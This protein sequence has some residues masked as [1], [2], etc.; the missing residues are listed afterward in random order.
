MIKMFKMKKVLSLLVISVF[1][2]VSSGHAGGK[3]Q[4]LPAPVSDR[5]FQYLQISKT[6][7]GTPLEVEALVPYALFVIG[8]KESPDLFIQVASMAYMI[9]QWSQEP[10][11]S[12]EK[13][14]QNKN[15]P[16]IILDKDI[17]DE[18]I[19]AH[20]LVV[21]GKNNTI[22]ERLKNSLKGQ[23]S[24]IEVIK[25][26]LSEGRD[27][28]VVSD[29]KAAF[30]LA[31]KRLYFKSGA[32]KGYFNF[33]KTRLLI[34]KGNLDGALFTL[35]NPDGI[36]GCGKPV[37]L[38]ISN[39]ENLSPEMLKVAQKRNKLVFKDLREALMAMDKERS[40]KVWESA[41]ETCYACHQGTKDVA[42]YRTFKPN[43][44]EHSYHHI[45]VKKF[46]VECTTCHKGKTK[47]VGY[48]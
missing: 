15:L 10:G 36:R 7:M 14:K 8:E 43:E 40:I 18:D 29:R 46:G 38:A 24:Y 45:I 4:I 27:V 30:Y 39:K 22:Y 34:E 23:D 35:D 41:M 17:S 32:Y 6:F 19:K 33:V 3:P 16:P 26:G 25:N 2:T 31:N 12:V 20:N 42:Q 37:I 9:G 11:T 1:M 28:M 21:V 48:Q 47:N 13:V 44:G 5:T